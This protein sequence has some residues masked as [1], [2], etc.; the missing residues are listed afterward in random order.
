MHC[1][2]RGARWCFGVAFEDAGL[3]V[4]LDR[5][6]SPALE[7]VIRGG[8][9]DFRRG[10]RWYELEVWVVGTMVCVGERSLVDACS[11]KPL[12][13]FEWVGCSLGSGVL[14]A[15]SSSLLVETCSM[16]LS[17][18]NVMVM[19]VTEAIA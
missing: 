11:A 4:R 8:L 1:V 12:S 5:M 18:A 3:A 15:P 6:D 10:L 19:G 13:L 9:A 16:A 2:P 7:G 14:V 17:V